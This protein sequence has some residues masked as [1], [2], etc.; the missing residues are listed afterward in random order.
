MEQMKAQAEHVGTRM[1]SDHITSVDLARR[2]FRL[3]GDSGVEYTCDALII[4]TG[5]KAKWL[6]LKARTPSRA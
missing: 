3:F 2:P 5:A 4:A 1:V 6:A